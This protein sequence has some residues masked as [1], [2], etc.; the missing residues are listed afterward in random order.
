MQI[1]KLLTISLFALLPVLAQATIYKW[2]DADGKVQYSSEKPAD[3]E[4]EKIKVDTQPSPDYSTY[5]RPGR[6]KAATND[7]A[8]ADKSATGD[9]SATEKRADMAKK[10]ESDKIKKEMC[11]E[12]RQT[13]DTIEGSGRVRIED[14]KGNI[15]FLS[16]AEIAARKKSEQDRVT[17][18]CK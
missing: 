17:K 14:A 16:D 6:D 3:A 7:S 15:N 8:K 12:A 9:K 18:Y 2:V 10:A 1:N 5:N 11:A 13:L 4:V